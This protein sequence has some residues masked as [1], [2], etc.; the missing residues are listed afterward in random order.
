MDARDA[1]DITIK[2]F[3]LKASDLADQSGVTATMLSRYRNK[4]QDLQAANAF[5]IIRSL[6]SEA[7]E[8]FLKLLADDP[9]ELPLARLRESAPAYTP[10][11]SPKNNQRSHS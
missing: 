9:S 8:Y 2:M 3:D 7:R 5:S 4:F 10:K 1:L 11:S 6:P